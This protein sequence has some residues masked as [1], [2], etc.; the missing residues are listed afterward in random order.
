MLYD[1]GQVDASGRVSGR[2]IVTA[3]HWQPHDSLE[4][5]L[6][7]GAIVLR[8]GSKGLHRVPHRP[9]IVIPAAARR[10][11]TIEPGDRVLLAA[12]PDYRTVII[13]PMS[14]LDDMVVR[15][16]TAHSAMEQRP[17]E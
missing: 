14:A 4:L 1:I 9:R 11:H 15:Y 5:L 8:A 17:D 7:A 16:H 10:R 6:I 2:D 13:Y 3:L 12:A